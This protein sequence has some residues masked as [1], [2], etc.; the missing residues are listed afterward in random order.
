MGTDSKIPEKRTGT[1]QPFLESRGALLVL[2]VRN[3]YNN[4]KIIPQ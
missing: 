4:I 2:K 3:C 1:L